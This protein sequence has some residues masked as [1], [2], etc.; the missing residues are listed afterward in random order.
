MGG[1]EDEER[2]ENEAGKDNLEIKVGS[3]RVRG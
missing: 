2:G 1:E 3:G